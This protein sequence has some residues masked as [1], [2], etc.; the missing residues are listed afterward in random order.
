MEQTL[1]MLIDGV[2]YSDRRRLTEQWL[3]T[4]GREFGV[5]YDD[6]GNAIGIVSDG[7]YIDLWNGGVYLIQ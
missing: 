7:Y 4:T 6:F 3:Q 1:L 2:A 5:C